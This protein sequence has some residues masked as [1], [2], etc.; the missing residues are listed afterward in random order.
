MHPHVTIPYIAH[1]DFQ[2]SK[3]S[4]NLRTFSPPRSSFEILLDRDDCI[5]RIKNSKLLSKLMA[6]QME[7]RQVDPV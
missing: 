5:L 1:W 7:D 4:N 6:P 2:N 3:N